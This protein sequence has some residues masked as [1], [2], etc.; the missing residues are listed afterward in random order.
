MKT[1]GKKWMAFGILILSVFFMA[2]GTGD[3]TPGTTQGE[4]TSEPTATPVPYEKG[5]VTDTEFESE[6]IGVRFTAP[7]NVIMATQE[8]MDIA[9]RQGAELMYGENADVLMDYAQLTSVTEMTATHIYGTNVV[10]QVE[11][12][13]ALYARMTEEQ[14]LEVL[15]NNLSSTMATS[16]FVYTFGENTSIEEIGGQ[17]YRKLSVMTDY[18]VGIMVY[19]DFCVRKID[20][21]MV[22][23]TFSY[24]E[25]TKEDAEALKNAFAPY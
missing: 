12:L 20:D 24:R 5:I 17:E 10:V 1:Q 15:K 7:A 3:G 11:K 4:P 23:F 13:S 18:G 19:Q 6:W 25:D 21:R 8:E 14:Y 2:C 22:A 16:G 9:M